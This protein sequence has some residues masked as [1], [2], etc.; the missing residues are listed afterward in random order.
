MSE[1]NEEGKFACRLAPSLSGDQP[2]SVRYKLSPELAD[3]D[4]CTVVDDKADLL[5]AVAAWCD[6]VGSDEG[7]SFSVTTVLMSDEDVAALPEV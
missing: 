7:E 4:H 3:G 6:E 5:R 1:A 2:V